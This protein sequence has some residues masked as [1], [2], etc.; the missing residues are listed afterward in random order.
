MVLDQLKKL[1]LLPCFSLQNSA[2][3]LC[4]KLVDTL[5]KDIL[6]SVSSVWEA[7]STLHVLEACVSVC[8]EVTLKQLHDTY[9]KG[10]LKSLAEASETKFS[11]TKLLEAV[12]D[13]ELV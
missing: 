2:P 13:K 10:R 11:V 6:P 3:E 9:F 7:S 1:T 8:D 12:K 4:Q 5:V